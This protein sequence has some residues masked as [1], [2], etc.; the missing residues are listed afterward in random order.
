MLTQRLLDG[1]GPV[2]A[3]FTEQQDEIEI[4]LGELAQIAAKI[5]VVRHRDGIVGQ[6]DWIV[7]LGGHRRRRRMRK[8][9]I[10]TLSFVTPCHYWPQISATLSAR[11]LH[12]GEV[13]DLLEL[14]QHR[15]FGLREE[16]NRHA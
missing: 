5:V 6:R 10:L 15:R 2:C 11:R 14:G 12:V 3:G 13:H 7:G 1:F 16:A 8:W 4:A 9:P